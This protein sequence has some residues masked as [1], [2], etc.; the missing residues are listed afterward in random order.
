MNKNKKS[1]SF[2]LLIV[3][4]IILAILYIFPFYIMLVNSLK[5]KKQL[6]KNVLAFPDPFEF[7]NYPNALRDLG[8]FEALTN[9]ILI[10]VFSIVFIVILSAMAAWMLARSKSVISNIIFFLFIAAML[11]PFQSVMLPLVWWMNKLNFLNRA[12]L[13]FMYIGFGS[14]FSIFLFH[15]FIKGI[16]KSL[17][18]AATIDG[19]NPF[20]VFWLIIIPILKPIIVTVAILNTIW[21]WND[22]LLPKL[23]LDKSSHETIPLR[24]FYFFGAY[25]KQWTR[26]MAGLTMAIIPVIIFYFIAQKQIVKG[27]TAGSIK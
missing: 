22:F 14:S 18:E 13:I 10:T 17:E 27:I 24:M 21:I 16:P 11:I 4:S 3:V 15:G 6:F 2:I 26:A 12:G 1:K 9:S 23:V 7:I 25:T 5:T 20:Q 8:F 19:C